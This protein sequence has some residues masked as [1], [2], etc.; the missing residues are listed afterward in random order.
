[1][2]TGSGDV[3]SPEPSRLL[4]VTSPSFWPRRLFL[5]VLAFLALLARADDKTQPGESSSLDFFSLPGPIKIA[6]TV[7]TNL[8]PILN[9]TNREYVVAR[10]ST[11]QSRPIEAGIRL[12]GLST[13]QPVERKPSFAVKFNHYDKGRRFH[14]LTKLFLN[15]SAIDQCFVREG[16][17]GT[18]F[19]ELGVPAARVRP[20]RVSLNGRD[21][22]IY[23]AVESMNKDFLQRSFGDASGNL[24]EGTLRD[25]SEP[26]E[27]DHGKDASQADR[28]AL[29]DA[30]LEPDLTIRWLKVTNLLD[31]PR[32]LSYAA[33]DAF[34]GHADGYLRNVNNYR[35]Y[36]DPISQKLVF[37]PHG[38]D[39]TF[40]TGGRLHPSTNSLIMRSLWPV[41][42][43]RASYHQSCWILA[44][45]LWRVPSISNH[46]AKNTRELEQ[47]MHSDRDVRRLR[48]CTEELIPSLVTRQQ[49]VLAE[50]SEPDSAPVD[51]APGTSVRIADWFS[52]T[53]LGQP[54]FQIQTNAT[55]IIHR[56]AGDKIARGEWSS[57][58]RLPAGSF[59]FQVRA[60]T[61]G[62]ERGATWP[63]ARIGITGQRPG[64]SVTTR[65]DWQELAVEFQLQSA[66]QGIEFRCEMQS[67]PGRVEFDLAGSKLTRL[68]SLP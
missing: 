6:L 51:I 18:L 8:F 10:I 48:L 53:L 62:T 52:R 35:L 15:N 36:G 5:G 2:S 7:D 28:R 50:L 9:R 29:V 45:N 11:E 22:G 16:L 42:M 38:L 17:A 59:R 46:L 20:V 25:I 58:V 26:L 57:R 47:L 63:M 4:N 21:L 40:V 12:K 23:L 13:F 30:I 55:E 67:G 34:L 3:L 24:Y 64:A 19:R 39:A 66:D 43:F 56:I 41:P 65:G 44:T 32:F 49:E 37:L 61:L 1:M 68:P 31:M 14:G 54:I 27:L 60:R 33:M